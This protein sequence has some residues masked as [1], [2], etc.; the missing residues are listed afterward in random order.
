MI[1][2]KDLLC[3][4]EQGERIKWDI[5]CFLEASIGTGFRTGL[6]YDMITRDDLPDATAIIGARPSRHGILTGIT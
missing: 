3:E 1:K 4:L 2:P 6:H 5:K